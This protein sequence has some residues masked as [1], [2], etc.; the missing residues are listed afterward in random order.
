MNLP[1][2][3]SFSLDNLLTPE[4][5]NSPTVQTIIIGIFLFVMLVLIGFSRRILTKSSMQGVWAGFVMGVL[6]IAIL[7]GG[8]L[9]LLKSLNTGSGVYVPDNLKAILNTSQ[10][11]FTQVLGVQT[12]RDVPT[13]QSVI[14]DYEVLSKLDSELVRGQ[15]CPSSSN[16]SG[17]A[18]E[19]VGRIQ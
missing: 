14:L 10:Q 19:P 6:A 15:V 17:Q 3:P 16:S 1:K 13:A 2:T 11:N 7:E 12:E 5:I 9:Y 8:F 4:S 18:E